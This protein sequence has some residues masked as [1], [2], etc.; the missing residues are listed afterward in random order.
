[1]AGCIPVGRVSTAE[2]TVRKGDLSRDHPLGLAP[3]GRHGSGHPAVDNFR[4]EL[5]DS[6]ITVVV[7]HSSRWTHRP[8]ADPGIV[9]P[10]VRAD[11]RGTEEVRPRVPMI[12]IVIVGPEVADQLAGFHAAFNPSGVVVTQLHHHSQCI[13]DRFGRVLSVRHRLAVTYLWIDL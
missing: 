12:L 2:G 7:E 11:L 8:I 9:H 10:V 4:I 6:G 13:A 5:G 3:I 1:M